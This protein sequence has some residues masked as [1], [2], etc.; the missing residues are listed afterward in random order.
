MLLSG[1]MRYLDAWRSTIDGVNS[2]AK[3]VNGKIMYPRMYGDDGWYNFMEDPFD[4]GALHLYY[5][6][7]ETSDRNRII[8]NSWLDYI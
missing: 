1:D 3:T 6:S 8:S 2:N 5:W 4:Q 7:M